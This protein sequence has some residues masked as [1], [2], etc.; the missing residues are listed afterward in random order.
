MAEGL[1]HPCL[2]LGDN[3]PEHR[4]LYWMTQRAR[5]R[6]Q[7]VAMPYDDLLVRAAWKIFGTSRTSEVPGI[8]RI[9]TDSN[10]I[11]RVDFEGSSRFKVLV[12]CLGQNPSGELSPVPPAAGERRDSLA[13]KALGW[14][15]ATGFEA[16]GLPV[17]RTGR[18]RPT[19]IGT[20]SS[21]VFCPP[22]AQ[23]SKPGLGEVV[24]LF[25]DTAIQ[26]RMM[27][28]GS[29][30]VRA[31]SRNMSR[32]V[33]DY[34]ISP[35]MIKQMIVEFSHHPEWCQRSKKPA[36]QVFVSRRT[37]LLSTVVYEQRRNPGSRKYHQDWFGRYKRQPV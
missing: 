8:L 20:P 10:Y 22:S 1:V 31:F 17:Q 26:E 7:L 5:S 16:V 6:D 13:P 25:M 33:K 18:A 12:R 23:N 30:D 29:M 34:E 19:E 4:L 3:T 32:W 9:L 28:P 11:D 15:G 14:P 36:W 35:Q 24:K 2:D 27:L 37:E 21:T